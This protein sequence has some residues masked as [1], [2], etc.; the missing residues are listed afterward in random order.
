MDK[1]AFKK[2]IFDKRI[3]HYINHPFHKKINEGQIS[4]EGVQLWV[5]N[6]Y[7]YQKILPK[8]DAIIVA[9]CNVPKVRRM[10]VDRVFEHDEMG[11]VLAW[12]SL[13]RA[14]GLT[15]KVLDSGSLVLP[16]VQ[17]SV[18]SYLNFCANSDY[19][20][21]MA[22]SITELFNHEVYNARIAN[23]PEHYPWINRISYEYYIEKIGNSVKDV[24]SSL[25]YILDHY[26]TKEEQRY[27]LQ[28]VDFKINILWYMLDVIQFKTNGP[29]SNK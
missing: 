29:K 9:K 17:Y 5:A 18:D 22:T 7:Y 27:A 16:A 4:K 26:K 28:L 24:D 21:A 23:W 11:G 13:G 6:R 12:R 10:W 14:V 3:N 1:L 15:D 2:V 19:H 20:D 8:K 25:D